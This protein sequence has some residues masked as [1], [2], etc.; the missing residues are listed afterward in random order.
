MKY[1]IILILTVFPTIHLY[2]EE[3]KF[4]DIPFYKGYYRDA[5][6]KNDTL[7]CLTDYGVILWDVSDK[8]L[9]KIISQFPL[10]GYYYDGSI[11]YANNYLIILRNELYVFD[12]SDIFH[13][14]QIYLDSL[15]SRVWNIEIKD[16]YLYLSQS[17]EKG[18]LVYDLSTPNKPKYISG[19]DLPFVREFIMSDDYLYVTFESGILKLINT[20][21]HLNISD[22]IF[23]QMDYEDSDNRYMQ[24]ENFFANDSL[25]FVLYNVME[26]AHDAGYRLC[27]IY[28]I[29]PPHEPKFIDSMKFSQ[30]EYFEYINDSTLFISN[31]D[32]LIYLFSITGTTIQLVDSIKTNWYSSN[33]IVLNGENLI[34]MN[35]NRGFSIFNRSTG[36]YKLFKSN[37]VG[38]W[39]NKL[40]ADSKGRLYAIAY[41]SVYVLNPSLENSRTQAEFTFPLTTSDSTY[42]RIQDSIIIKFYVNG[43]KSRYISLSTIVNFEKIDSLTSFKNIN[44]PENGFRIFDNLLFYNSQGVWDITNIR[45]PVKVNDDMDLAFD[46]K[47]SNILFDYIDRPNYKVNLYTFEPKPVFLKSISLTSPVSDDFGFNIIWDYETPDGN[48]YDIGPESVFKLELKDT[49]NINFTPRYDINVGYSSKIEQTIVH[50][51]LLFLVQGYNIK[52]IDMCD[53]YHHRIV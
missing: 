42:I 6:L 18:L 40:L 1:F 10:P 3:I 21:G 26:N 45:Q 23:V 14:K 38:C 22:S 37:T 47:Y 30:F 15:N 39:I 53:Q 43:S 32:S 20:D 7:I 13:P 27:N 12:I 50:K 29:L 52:V 25:L 51:D 16:K 24:F 34:I 31:N 4:L 49:S 11:K 48:C 19:I 17:N 9:P 2:G 46:Y 36:R 44:V 8:E 33:S 28:N 35:A 5:E 41:D